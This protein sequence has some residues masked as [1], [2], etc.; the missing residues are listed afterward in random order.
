MPLVIALWVALMTFITIYVLTDWTGVLI[1]FIVLLTISLVA[2]FIEE[3][4]HGY[5]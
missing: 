5:H 4:R 1:T 3:S 2:Y